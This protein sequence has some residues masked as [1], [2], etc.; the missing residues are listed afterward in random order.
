MGSHVKYPRHHEGPLPEPAAVHLLAHPGEPVPV[1]KSR[2]EDLASAMLGAL[3]VIG[4]VVVLIDSL[5][6][7]ETSAAVGPGAVPTFVAV[8]L[9]VLGVVLVARALRELKG[10]APDSELSRDHLLRLAAMLGLLVSFAVLLPLV[11]YVVTSAALFTGATLLLGAPSKGRAI[12]YGW[13]LAAVVFLV[14]D[15]L[16]GLTLPAGPWGF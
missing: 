2:T 9:A 15:R 5:S 4:A 7:P 14:F 8:G 3:M 6:L 1:G 16:I 12:A 11:G 10:A 13:T